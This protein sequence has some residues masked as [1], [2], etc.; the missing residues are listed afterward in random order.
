MLLDIK[1]SNEAI[2][3]VKEMIAQLEEIPDG[4]A[5]TFPFEVIDT[6]KSEYL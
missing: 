5:E 2:E 3:L 6:L 1:H 4:C